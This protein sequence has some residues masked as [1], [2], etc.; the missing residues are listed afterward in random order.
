MLLGDCVSCTTWRGLEMGKHPAEGAVAHPYRTCRALMFHT[1]SGSSII[2]RVISIM[3]PGKAPPPWALCCPM[4]SQEAWGGLALYRNWGSD[5]G[6][7]P[8]LRSDKNRTYPKAVGCKPL[9]PNMLSRAGSEVC[10]MFVVQGSFV[11][12]KSDMG[13]LRGASMKAEWS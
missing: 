9:P 5:R 2:N 13:A 6:R 10:K 11:Q 12:T 1:F 4:F 8:W 7:T 3:V